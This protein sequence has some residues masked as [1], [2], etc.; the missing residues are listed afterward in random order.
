MRSGLKIKP[1]HNEQEFA[2]SLTNRIFDLPTRGCA[3]VGSKP[4]L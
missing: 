2:P 4:T 3:F 1:E